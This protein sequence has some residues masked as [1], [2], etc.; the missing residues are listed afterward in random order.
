MATMRH[1]APL[2]VGV[3]AIC[4]STKAYALEHLMRVGEVLISKN[5]D[6]GIQFVELEDPGLEPFP[7]PPYKLVLY[8]ANATQLGSAITLNVPANT[9]RVYVSTGAADTAFGTTGDAQLGVT[10]PAN[11]QACFVNAGNV[12]IM[13]LAWGCINTLVV[14]AQR[15]PSPPD[16][17]SVQRQALGG[18]QIA[19]PTPD[20]ANQAGT[21]AANCPTDPDAPP[22]P[23]AG[24]PPDGG[25]DSGTSPD[26]GGG[27]NN[28]G[29]GG[30]CCQVDGSR[31]AA[32]ALLLAFVV[33]VALRTSRRKASR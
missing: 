31:G 5:G 8:D 15:A 28:N 25:L 1:L 29:D 30:G 6:T 7:N 27:N 26:G 10:L 2:V 22:T 17:M 13:C 14:G 16:N 20:A 9:Q 4:S 21:M 23:D 19:T 33:L 32:G 12:N 3:L 11:G 24:V 18:Y